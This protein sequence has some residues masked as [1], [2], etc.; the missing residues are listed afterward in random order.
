MQIIIE[1]KNQRVFKRILDLLKITEWLGGVRIWKKENA[2][3][4]EELVYDF[5]PASPPTPSSID[6][7]EFWA[8]I[9]PPMGVEAIDR[10][11]AEMRR[12]YMS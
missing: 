11:I 6:Y 4:E 5:D 9:Q 1:V 3:A 7:R 8:C 10:Q 2:Q 12:L